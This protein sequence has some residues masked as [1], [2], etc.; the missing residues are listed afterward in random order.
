MQTRLNSF[1]L[2]S[3]CGNHIYVAMQTVPQRLSTMIAKSAPKTLA[4]TLSSQS[5]C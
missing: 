1:E 3:Q 5:I 2:L 4:Y